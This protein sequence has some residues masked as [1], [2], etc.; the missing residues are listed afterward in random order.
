MPSIR[1]VGAARVRA[2]AAAT[3]ALLGP[4]VVLAPPAAASETVVGTEGYELPTAAPVEVVGPRATSQA[5][6]EVVPHRP[7]AGETATIEV[8]VVGVGE[9][10]EAPTGW[11]NVTIGGH[12]GGVYELDADGEAQVLWQV[13]GSHDREITV[14]YLG[15]P[16]FEASTS[17]WSVEI[18]PAP[19]D[20]WDVRLAAPLRPG[21]VWLASNGFAKGYADGTFDPHGGLTRQAGVAFLH[22]LRADPMPASSCQE[23]PFLDV[24]VDHPFC[25]EIAALASDGLVTGYADGTF[26]PELPLSRQAVAAILHRASSPPPPAVGPSCYPRPFTDVGA[27]HPY[28]RPI[29]WM[30]AEAV[31][32]GFADRSFR[33]G[34][35]VSREA[36]AAFLARWAA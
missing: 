2:L 9:A 22:R 24:P 30:V 23:A 35:T 19:S 14:A 20:F 6:I 5:H 26:G 8:E 29:A 17:S 1:S 33:P 12:A 11:I 3:L 16:G 27:D 28:C 18:G 32:T 4:L 10:P 34:E 7:V 21:V 13:W 36:M 25:V 31:T 15:S